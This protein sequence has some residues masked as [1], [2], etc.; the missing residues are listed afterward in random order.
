MRWKTPSSDLSAASTVQLLAC[1]R[2]H[3][4]T[5][6]FRGLRFLGVAHSFGRT[7]R[8]ELGSALDCL[9]FGCEAAPDGACR[10]VGASYMSCAAVRTRHS[11]DEKGQGI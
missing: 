6:L 3:V 1:G 8:S 10:Q 11:C 2:G 5:D 9:S 4:A 7:I